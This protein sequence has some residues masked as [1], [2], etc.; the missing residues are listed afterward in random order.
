MQGGFV[1]HTKVIIASL[2]CALAANSNVG[3]VFFRNIEKAGKT[4]MSGI[5]CDAPNAENG[6]FN[7]TTDFANAGEE[8]E[9]EY[10]F[11]AGTIGE[12]RIIS[13]QT[14][15]ALQARTITRDGSIF[16]RVTIPQ[17]QGDYKVTFG[18]FNYYNASNGIMY[19]YS[20]GTKG[21]AS[22]LSADDAREKFFFRYVASRSCKF[23][24]LN[25]QYDFNLDLGNL[26]NEMLPDL[27][28]GLDFPIIDNPRFSN[29][30]QPRGIPIDDLTGG[31]VIP[32][33]IGHFDF[34][35]S[36]NDAIKEFTDY[37]YGPTNDVE[38]TTKIYAKDGSP[39]SMLLGT[40]LRVKAKWVDENGNQHPLIGV[41]VS[42]LKGDN[43]V[44]PDDPFVGAPKYYTDN[45]GTANL[46]IPDSMVHSL[47]FGNISIQLSS[48]N[49]A[50][51]IEDGL[52]LN[53]PYLFRNKDNDLVIEGTTYHIPNSECISD[54]SLIQYDVVVYPERSDRASSYEICEAEYVP[55]NY[56]ATFAEPV[57]AAKVYY[58]ANTIGYDNGILKFDKHDYNNWDVLNH[59]YG[60]HICNE[61]ELCEIPQGRLPHKIHEDLSQ[62]YGDELGLKLAY[63][64]GLAT[65]LGIASQMYGGSNLDVEGVGDEIYED[66]FRNVY[67]D[68]NE[69][70]PTSNGLAMLYQD[71]VEASVTSL[72]IKLLD[73]VVR[74]G[75]TVALGDS[76][77]CD[78]IQVASWFGSDLNIFIEAVGDWCGVDSEIATVIL[79][80]GLRVPTNWDLP[81]LPNPN[82]GEWTI[83]MYMLDGGGLSVPN[84]INEMLSA[85]CDGQSSKIK[86]V[87]ETN[88]DYF[89]SYGDGL[90][91]YCISD[92]GISMCGDP[93]PADN[94][95]KQD[96]FEEFLA[97]GLDNYPAKKTGVIFFDHGRGIQGVCFDT[98]G[99]DRGQENP[100]RVTETSRALD[101]VLTA[102]GI[103]K[104]EFVG[105]DACLMQLQDVA[106]F[107]SRYFNYMIGSEEE[108]LAESMWD[109]D[110][111]LP[112]LFAN[113]DT[114][115]ILKGIADGMVDEYMHGDYDET[116]TWEQHLS[117]LDLRHMEEYHQRFEELA[118]LLLD[119]KS[120]GYTFAASVNCN[121]Y[122]QWSHD[123]QPLQH[124]MVD[125]VQYLNGLK[126]EYNTKA[127]YGE[128]PSSMAE[129]VV[130]KIDAVLSVLLND[131]R[132]EVYDD[133]SVRMESDNGLV[134][135]F[136]ASYGKQRAQSFSYGLA[137]HV[138]TDKSEQ[139][140][141]AEE[142]HFNNW[143]NLFL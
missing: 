79:N 19:I 133:Y 34:L 17:V 54:Y 121:Y 62:I 120:Q 91:R 12:F 78:I 24:L 38:T 73:N 98:Y 85:A 32:P 47:T 64:E 103:D 39:R 122:G 130:T 138:Y 92:G 65:Y 76:D 42:F 77:M 67:V 124:G 2:I 29:D 30:Y 134:R 81:D 84:Q 132:R 6:Y 72:M 11:E 137:I 43:N 23:E 116:T 37:V 107:N 18:R 36:R 141:P 44:V 4:N 99:M 143:R 112:L 45:S 13:S 9:G 15:S 89:D 110:A 27:T 90:F 57:G 126:R 41:K 117:V 118:G 127:D 51:A 128:I 3:K 80:E 69:F 71:A 113:E 26:H 101:N 106:E 109:Y 50:V 49:K 88:C 35:S 123:A 46:K 140:Y 136:R 55:Y 97:W 25:K 135:Y 102:R 119:H 16:V 94:M 1:M 100:L 20:D 129:Q 83:L 21:V 139:V 115:T 111:W 60:H 104:L 96:T 68:Y 48:I 8:I 75:D 53:Y 58:P 95:G 93:L 56:A 59:E 125:C 87:M 66:A 86:I 31:I 131:A 142:T 105:Y 5:V 14:S 70:N 28:G 22:S 7:I 114:L 82:Q 52:G 74:T 108:E 61:L 10:I 40:S 63:S 33:T